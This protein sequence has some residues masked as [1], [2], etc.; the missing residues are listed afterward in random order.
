MRM[1]IFIVAVLLSFSFNVY[2]NSDVGITKA[3]GFYK[4]NNYSEA[5]KICESVL[6]KENGNQ[7]ALFLAGISHFMLKNYPYAEKY[8]TKFIGVKPYHYLAIKYLAIS[9]YYNGDYAGSISF[10]EKIPKYYDDP[11]V[12]VYIALNYNR[13]QDKENLISA[14]DKIEKNKKISHNQKKEFIDIINNAIKGDLEKTIYDLK[15]F[16]DKY[17]DQY[18]ISSKIMSIEKITKSGTSDNLRLMIAINEAFDTNVV[19]YPDNDAIKLPDVRYKERY[20]T[21]TEARYSLGY[22]FINSSSNIL[23]IMYNGYQGLNATLGSYNF[24]SNSLSLIYK[25]SRP[26]SYYF[27]VSYDY[28]YDF[29]SDKYKAYSFG[30]KLTPEFGLLYEKSLFAIGIPAHLRHYFEKT[31]SEDYNRSSLLIDP[32]L[33]FSH[34]FNQYF[35]LYNKDYF[36]INNAEGKAWKYLRPEVRIGVIYRYGKS[37]LLNL[38]GGFGYYMF[39]EKISNPDYIN[40]DKANPRTD[41]RFLFETGLD[42]RLY[43]DKLYLNTGYS[44]LMNMS[45]VKSGFFD[46]SRHIGSAGLK[47]IY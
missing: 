12:L 7:D 21:R 47:Y 22:R 13:L 36:G 44:F 25:F 29:I 37:I 1:R 27:G 30:H 32:Y 34:S 3:F 26:S 14:I 10:F 23:G 42:F 4:E 28:S 39:S 15:A 33:Y 41:M 20:D 43:S 5:I 11:V 17:N 45:D 2:A 18:A 35:T 6:E 8:L 16:R 38:S 31:Y 19:L 46:F 9:K 24:N 40:D